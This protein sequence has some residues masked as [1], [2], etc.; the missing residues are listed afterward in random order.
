[1]A[2]QRKRATVRRSKSTARTKARKP[3][4]AARRKGAKPTAAKPMPRKRLAKAKP[5]RS[6]TK[7]LARKKMG[8]MKGLSATAVETGIVDVTEEPVASPA[9]APPAA[10]L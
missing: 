7:K 10:I 4:K 9:D 6:G 2:Q 1:M 8:A 3:S 5:G